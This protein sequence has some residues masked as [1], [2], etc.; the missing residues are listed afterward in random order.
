[1][2]QAAYRKL[3]DVCDVF[4]ISFLPKR[5][6]FEY[7]KILFEYVTIFNMNDIEYDLLI[8]KIDKRV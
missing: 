6:E 1:M 2:L 3:S 4:L 7:V 5:L 8:E